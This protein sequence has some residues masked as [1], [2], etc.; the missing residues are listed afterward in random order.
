MCGYVF[1]SFDQE[2]CLDSSENVV[3]LEVVVLWI[4]V[5]MKIN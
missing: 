1:I 5:R 4:Y 2:N 3:W